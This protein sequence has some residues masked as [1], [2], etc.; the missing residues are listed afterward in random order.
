MYTFFSI[1]VICATV[2]WI[3]HKLP[4]TIHII[5]TYHN[6][7]HLDDRRFSVEKVYKDDDSDNIND[8]T[9]NSLDDVLSKIQSAINVVN[10]VEEDNN[11]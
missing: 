10:G 6:H 2:L 1:L 11:G 9:D 5:H 4:N 7:E 8:P 3:F